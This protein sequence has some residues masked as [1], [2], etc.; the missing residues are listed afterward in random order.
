MVA[1]PPK[2]DY[3][4][5]YASLLLDGDGLPKV[6]RKGT[7]PFHSPKVSANNDLLQLSRHGPV[8]MAKERNQELIDSQQPKHWKLC[9]K[10]RDS[11]IQRLT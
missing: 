1:R 3:R 2:V 5:L 6:Q 7:S 4:I 11:V 9:Q 10:M 8:R